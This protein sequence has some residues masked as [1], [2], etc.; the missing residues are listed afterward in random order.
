MG[1]GADLMA[2][3][4]DGT[5]IPVEIGLSPLR[6]ED[7]HEVLAAVVD[8]SERVRTAQTLAAQSEELARSNE[9]L[10]QFAYVAS[11]DL[12]EPLRMISGYTQLLARRFGEQL[13]EEAHEF[14]RYTVEG[15]DRMQRLIQALLDFSRVRTRPHEFEEVSLA[16]TVD[17]ALANLTVAISE[18]GARVEADELPTVQADRTQIG[19]LFQN[20]IGNG[21][22]FRDGRPPEIRVSAE[23][24][25]GGW[26]VRVTDNGIGIEA[27]HQEQIFQIF[28][29]L[30]RSD[31]EGTGIGLAVCKRIVERHHGRIWVTSEPGQGST[32]SFTLPDC[33]PHAGEEIPLDRTA[34]GV[35]VGK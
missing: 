4:K 25:D 9:E 18:T 8:M 15:V 13:D 32:F 3:R 7:G 31:R 23:R 1:A 28:Q 2:V 6:T 14:I 21:I 19:Q 11:H 35:G 20:L 30:N 26:I 22:K 33:V 5:E 24:G 10:Q 34:G 17:W 16:E 12:Q 29:R 27:K